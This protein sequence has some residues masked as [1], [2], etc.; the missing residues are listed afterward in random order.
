MYIPYFRRSSEFSF[1][2]IART[3]AN[4]VGGFLLGTSSSGESYLSEMQIEPPLD[5]RLLADFAVDDRK[6]GLKGGGEGGVRGRKASK[7]FGEGGDLKNSGGSPDGS[8]L[9]TSHRNRRSAAFSRDRNKP[10]SPAVGPSG[11]RGN[12]LLSRCLANER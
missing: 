7:V 11:R 2:S 5:P 1:S 9:D 10:T 8:S 3:L 12:P 4:L 6:M